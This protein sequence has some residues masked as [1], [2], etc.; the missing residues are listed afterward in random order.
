MGGVQSRISPQQ[1]Y[2]STGTA[3]AALAIDVRGADDFDADDVQIVGA[4]RRFP[5]GSRSGRLRFPAA[6]EWS[7]IACTVNK[8][9]KAWRPSCGRPGGCEPSGGRHH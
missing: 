4:I 9:A 7:S 1:L 5:G 6:G 8:L 2:Q 3:A